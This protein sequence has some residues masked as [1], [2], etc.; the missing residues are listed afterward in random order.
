M[1]NR[2]KTYWDT[3][4]D[5][6]QRLTSISTNDF[7]FGPLLPGNNAMNILPE[8]NS[9]TTCLELGCGAAQ[10]SIFLAKQGAQCT[11]VDVSPQQIRHAEELAHKNCVSISLSCSPLENAAAWPKKQFDL[12][13]SVYTLPFIEKPETFIKR[14]A[15][16]TA[17]GGTFLLVTKH[18]VFCAE[19]LELED[20]ETGLFLP[21]Y[22][23]PDEDIR[24]N[25]DGE[26]ISSKAY[27][28]STISNLMHKSGLSNLQLWEPQPL[29]LTEI[30]KAPY[31]SPAWIELH[32]KLAAAPVS[33]IYSARKR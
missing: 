31:K 28:I 33:I 18:P 13:H 6:Y 32:P 25:E 3:I 21:S 5:D 15:D 19:W 27:P 22:F 9:D 24:E 4:A 7:H 16:C 12:V 10:N 23:E 20:E 8:I 11:A 1:K 26:L 2:Q 29:P 17:P 14:A 30:D